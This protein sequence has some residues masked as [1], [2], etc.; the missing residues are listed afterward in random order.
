MH[1]EH[2]VLLH[3]DKCR[4]I[5]GAGQFLLALR[6]GDL[7]QTYWHFHPGITITWG[8]ALIL[9]LQSFGSSLPLEEFVAFQVEN[10]ALSVGPMRLS[11]VVLTSLVLP[12][13]YALARPF[14]GRWAA[15]LGVGL[16]AVDPFWVAHSR[17]VNGDALTGIL[18]AAAYIA[19]ALLLIKPR[20][21][22]AIIAGLF[23]GLSF[24]TKLPSQIL[25]PAIIMLAI[26]G[27]FKDRNW[28]FW[29]KA[30]VLCG[31]AVP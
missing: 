6:S 9:W 20:L 2:Y 28:R 11:G 5:H 14:M 7:T 31:Q 18:M 30:L 23:A 3:S 15:I 29:L 27:Y 22:L 10:L 19:F 25:I 13:V 26:I 24:L 16:L 21:N 12:F 4:W 1:N 8:E 17:I